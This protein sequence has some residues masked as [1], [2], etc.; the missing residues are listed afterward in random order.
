MNTTAPPQDELLTTIGPV[1]QTVEGL[2]RRCLFALVVGLVATGAG[3][4]GKAL[5]S[6]AV[7]APCRLLG[8][9]AA[10]RILG[11]HSAV[12]SNGVVRCLKLRDDGRV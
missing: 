5:A 7:P 9:A 8:Q 6:A 4:G 3:C 11:Y 12:L 10:S 2:A 1:G